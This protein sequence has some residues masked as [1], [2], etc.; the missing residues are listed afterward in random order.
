MSYVR[1]Q[2]S[3]KRL[4]LFDRC[5]TFSWATTYCFFRKT[6]YGCLICR[7]T[8]LQAAYSVLTP[9]NCRNVCPINYLR[10]NRPTAFRC[11]CDDRIYALYSGDEGCRRQR[12][13]APPQGF[14]YD[15]PPNAS[16]KNT[17]FCF[18]SPNR[19]KMTHHLSHFDTVSHFDPFLIE[20][21]LVSNEKPLIS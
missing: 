21:D 18:N 8:T 10:G 19:V 3:L 2:G 7:L 11:V 14:A 1:P 9:N 13:C 15:R 16:V 12:P 6:P 5:V 20:I 17:Q 4:L